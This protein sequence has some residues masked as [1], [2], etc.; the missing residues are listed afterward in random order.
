MILFWPIGTGLILLSEEIEGDGQTLFQHACKLGLEGIIG[1]R[2]D[3]PYRSGRLGDWI[4]VKCVQSDSFAIVGYEPSEAMRGMIGR[5]LLAARREGK[6]VYVGGVGT[7]FTQKVLHDLKKR[8][9]AIRTTTPPVK[10]KRKG[11]VFVEPQAR[12]RD[13]VPRLDR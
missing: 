7:G 12:R 1:K 9:D 4:K 5:L 8:L 3:K 11:A 13:R 6:L 2:R 10:L